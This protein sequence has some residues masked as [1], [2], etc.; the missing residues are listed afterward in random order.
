MMPNIGKFFAVIT[1]SMIKFVGGPLAGLALQMAWYETA[2]CSAL[3][4]MMT[5]ALVMFFYQLIIQFLAKKNQHNHKVT[6][7]KRIRLAVSVRNRLGLLGIAFL[8]PLL[9]TPIGGTMIAVAFKYNKTE[10]ALKM[11][12]SAI[13][14]A[15][16]QTLFFYYLK[17][18][19]M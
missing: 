10:I 11:L 4:M 2:F 14:W 17:D 15:I 12:L 18:I 5:V 3:G 13:F 1:A 9:F 6:F 8:T 19:L 16:I 7:N